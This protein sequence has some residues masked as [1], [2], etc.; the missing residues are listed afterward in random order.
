MVNFGSNIGYGTRHAC[1]RVK[2]P[3]NLNI[4]SNKQLLAAVS[5]RAYEN[6]ARTHLVLFIPL[7]FTGVLQRFK[8]KTIACQRKWLNRAQVGDRERKVSSLEVSPLASVGQ[9]V[10]VEIR[11]LTV[12]GR[13]GVGELGVDGALAGLI[14]I[15]TRVE[16]HH[17][18]GT[19]LCKHYI[20]L[21]G[22]VRHGGNA[23]AGSLERLA[24]LYMSF[25]SAF[26]KVLP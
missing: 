9:I 14:K 5:H 4:S 16:L 20:R 13:L 7:H 12:S 23:G 6:N 10:Y 22:S 26:C 8:L 18:L 15:L 11:L 19:D 2:R 24:S 17:T 1:I 21:A 3:N 25:L